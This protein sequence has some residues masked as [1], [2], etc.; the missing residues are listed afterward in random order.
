MVASPTRKGWAEVKTRLETFDRK[1]LVSLVRDLY[2]ASPANR[3]FLDSR[4]VPASDAIEKYRRLVTDAIYPDPFSRRRI[5]VRDAGAVITEYRR[6]TGDPAGT[7]DLM[8]TF[9]E[10]GTEQSV[11]L[12]YG[13]DDYFDALENKLKAIVK[14]LDELP[15]TV[16]ATA[17]ARLTHVRDR[18]KDI[19]WGYGDFVD[20]VVGRLERRAEPTHRTASRSRRSVS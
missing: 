11:D 5:S 12:G 3:R 9:V 7:V 6:S 20:D 2:E 4:L 14:A 19:G 16:R 18:A 8:L 10:A 13:D 17:V 1:G 15:A